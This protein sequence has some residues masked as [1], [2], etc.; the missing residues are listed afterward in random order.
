M[1]KKNNSDLYGWYKPEDINNISLTGWLS[2]DPTIKHRGGR[3]YAVFTLRFRERVWG[4][5]HGKKNITSTVQCIIT[6]EKFAEH[7][8]KYYEKGHRV[9]I[10]GRLAI[11]HEKELVNGQSQIVKLKGG[12][13]AVRP[14]IDI[15]HM[16]ILHKHNVKPDG[17]I[18]HGIVGPN[19]DTK[20]EDT[21]IEN[22]DTVGA[23]DIPPPRIKDEENR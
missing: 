17:E 20:K 16:I 23:K 9:A 4:I 10:T 11:F 12:R 8:E 18:P 5:F 22:M 13:P 1:V 19:P 3:T 2:Q 21:T 14:W 6:N 15:S 7:A